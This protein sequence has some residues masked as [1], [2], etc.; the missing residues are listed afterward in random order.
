[1][2]DWQPPM[3]HWGRPQLPPRGMTG[4]LDEPDTCAAGTLKRFDS[5]TLPQSG[6]AGFSLPRTRVSKSDWHFSQVYS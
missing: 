4:K 5:F 3:P 6:Q 1:M 2:P